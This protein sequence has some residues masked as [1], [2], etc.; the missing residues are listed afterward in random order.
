MARRVL[1]N[2][3]R[4][5]LI[6]RANQRRF[7]ALL[8]ARDYDE[9]FQSVMSGSLL[10]TRQANRVLDIFNTRK[11]IITIEHIAYTDGIPMIETS[12]ILSNDRNK[13]F[14]FDILTKGFIEQVQ[15]EY[16]SD[17]VDNIEIGNII[18]FDIK[19][20]LPVQGGRNQD[21]GYFPYINTTELDLSRYQIFNQAQAYEEDDREHCLIQALFLAGIEITKLTA[22]KLSFKTGSNFRKKDLQQA[23]EIIG[24]TIELHEY[25]Y[26]SKRP[27]K[28]KI[29]NHAE[30]VSI[31]LYENHF[32]IYEDTIY[33]K[34]FIDNYVEL[35]HAPDAFNIV[36]KRGNSCTYST[37]RKI[38]SLSMAVKL[39]PYFKKLDMIKFNEATTDNDHVYL[40]NI[41][42]EQRPVEPSKPRRIPS[43]I[44]YADCESFV[45]K[46]P[47]E[48]YL[49][50]VVSNDN[51][52][53][54]IFNTCD[55][56]AQQVVN[57]FLDF[58]S[59]KGS[60]IVYFHNLKYDY[61]LLE[62]Y[63][64]IKSVCK[65]DGQI[66]NA[67]IC[68]N[69]VEIELRDSYKLIPFALS[70]FA[71]QFNLENTKKEAINYTYYRRENNGLIVDTATYKA[72]LSTDLQKIFDQNV[73]TSNFNPLEYYK[74]Y[75]ELDCLVLKQ[76]LQ[77]F[78]EI[79][80]NI[81]QMSIHE[82]LT[83]SSLTDKYMVKSG[84]YSGVYE[85]KGNLR[86]YI[87]KAVYGGRVA[88][89]E[90]YKKKII[91]GKISDYDGVSLYPSA[92]HRLCSDS[93][94]PLG[95]AKRIYQDF[96]YK[97]HDYSVL[98]VKIHK[99][100]KNQQIPFIA[101]RNDESI[102]YLNEAPD[103]E[104]V[105][106]STTLEDYINFH[107]IEYTILDG[108]YWSNGVNKTMGQLIN[109]L[110]NERL[111]Y[112][113]SNPTLANVVKLM[114][115]SAYGKTIIKKS[116]CQKNIIKSSRFDKYIYSNFNTVKSYRQINDNLYE[117]ERLKMDDS[118]NR[119]HIGC[120]I[121]STSKR[122]MN[123]VF[124]VANDN[125]LPIYYTD[126]DSL[127]MNMDDVPRLERAYRDRY[128]K[129][130]NGKNLGQFHTDFS[131]DN[132]A[133]EIYATKS[134]FLGKKSYIDVL[135]STDNKGDIITGFHIRLKGI[136]QEGIDDQAKLCGGYFPMFKRLADGEALDFTLNPYN[137]ENNSQ[138]VLF[139]FI[140]GSVST[141]TE[142][143]RLV[144]F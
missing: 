83:I 43:N 76:G 8:R 144:Q 134:I 111:K 61:H 137:E 52:C 56:P 53:V 20:L 32:F 38:N 60:S 120:A 96:N 101:H 132:A 117:V 136:T 75:L 80:Q 85:V 133:T 57:R 54:S 99:V 94:L 82:S 84:A 39:Q 35:L 41:H 90:K 63:L 113:K 16:G 89:N 6:D 119:A 104:I 46:Q 15:P 78:N 72:G 19:E 114:L 18:S 66:Y 3:L 126:T 48:L 106:D 50:G 71:S 143:K 88:V 42:N 7:E 135:E 139:E 121:L 65:K 116:T 28:K 9:I 44:Y 29:G 97:K 81:T 123:E 108:V 74:E 130:L 69:K 22:L 91:E 34:Y 14:F 30:S 26:T 51:D 125:N 13:S 87:N 59:S 127:H 67:V 55:E 62:K 2:T 124:N 25:D 112:K 128:N 70:K 105:I 140:N 58:C 11:Y 103:K 45:Y 118:Y 73:T 141:R 115:N 100:N 17:I 10:T 49:L 27:K 93:G 129:E 95:K 110:F 33:S 102:E 79:V 31:A 86:A 23:S 77:K 4:Q 47:H 109:N 1:E 5:Q 68:H 36:K 138:K 12:S 64:N 40:D 92:I 98:T 21:G 107:S 122:I 142:F 37:D 131:L 24:K